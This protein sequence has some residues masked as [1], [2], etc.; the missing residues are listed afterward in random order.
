MKDDESA[1]VRSLGT[2]S[3]PPQRQRHHFLVAF[4]SIPPSSHKPR[5]L[6]SLRGW[7][8][9]L[10]QWVKKTVGSTLSPI[11][12]KSLMNDDHVT[13]S[14]T[15]PSAPGPIINLDFVNLFPSNFSETGSSKKTDTPALRQD[16]AN[17][18]DYD[19]LFEEEHGPNATPR[20]GLD[21]HPSYQREFILATEPGQ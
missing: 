3:L 12:P 10:E 16:L 9:R 17:E 11:G 14:L 2:R 6:I 19:C 8:L 15:N 7:Q 20:A 4:S 13:K 18:E 5:Y 1:E 21:Q